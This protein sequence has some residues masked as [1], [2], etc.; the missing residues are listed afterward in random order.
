MVVM[1]LVLTLA[2]CAKTE[3]GG[4]TKPEAMS[5][6]VGADVKSVVNQLDDKQKSC[7]EK[8]KDGPADAAATCV[9]REELAKQVM[10]LLDD[11]LPGDTLDEQARSCFEDAIKGLSDEELADF[12]G[13][14]EAAMESFQR[15]LTK[16]LD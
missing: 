15:T 12:A 7:I 2:G 1:C 3:S 6:E 11:M 13:G 4:A 10:K 14:D 16:C 5:G 8:D 9:E